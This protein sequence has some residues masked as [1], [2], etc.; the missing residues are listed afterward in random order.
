MINIIYMIFKELNFKVDYFKILDNVSFI[1]FVPLN[2]NEKY[3]RYQRIK[4]M[5]QKL[6]SVNVVGRMEHLF[7][8]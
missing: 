2:I 1:F 5:M 4:L 7:S 8:T 6:I 3:L